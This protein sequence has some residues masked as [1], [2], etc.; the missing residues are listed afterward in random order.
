[1]K[2]YIGF[3][4]L[5]LFIGCK[6]DKAENSSVPEVSETTLRNHLERLASDDFMGRKPFTEGEVKTVNYLKTEFEKL[7]LLPGNGDSFF[8]DVP[9]VEING[10]PSEN[11]VIAGKNN[12]FNFMAL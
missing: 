10:T 3:L 6:N 7:G 11:M 12:S 9:M 1:M 5:V 4:L 8:Q 2:N